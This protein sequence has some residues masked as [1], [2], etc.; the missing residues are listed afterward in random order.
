MTL[1]RVQVRLEDAIGWGRVY[2]ALSRAKSLESLWV[3]GCGLTSNAAIAAHPAVAQFYAKHAA[4]QPTAPQPAAPP[5][6]A[7]ETAQPAITCE[8]RARTEINKRKALA[9]KYAKNNA[10]PQ[11][12]APPRH[13]VPTPQRT[14]PQPPPANE[15]PRPPPKPP[16]NDE[17]RAKIEKNRQC[18]L[19][20][21]KKKGSAASAYP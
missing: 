15:N 1:T 13:D 3:A 9:K 18:A 7:N 4:L 14:A 12:S 11:P 19:E 17:L 2:V 8:Q 16:L 10:P 6:S 5:R 21:R 20:K